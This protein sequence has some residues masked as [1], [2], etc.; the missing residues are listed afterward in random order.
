MTLQKGN[1]VEHIKLGMN[2]TVEHADH[3][4]VRVKWDGG[5]IGMLFW[6]NSTVAHARDLIKLPYPTAPQGG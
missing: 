2:G 1:R 5:G 6:D 3:N 4:H